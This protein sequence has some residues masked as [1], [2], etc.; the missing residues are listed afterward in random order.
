MIDKNR[1]VKLYWSESRSMQEIA[2]TLGVSLHKVAYWMDKHNIDRRSRSDAGYLKHNPN[3]DPFHIKKPKNI[4]EA[5]LFGMG[6]GLYWGEGTKADKNSVRLGNADPN[7]IN[8]FIGFLCEMCGVN[9]EKLRFQLQI[10]N[11]S[12]ISEE[13]EFWISKLDISK[14]QM[15]KTMV[16][17]SRGNGTYRKKLEHG[18]ITL[19]YGNTKLRNELVKLLPI[20]HNR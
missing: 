20:W 16:T 1:L 4:N 12:D 13:E 5:H 2:D 15:Y 18:V 14:S 17:P 3:G 10:F 8:V 7:L 11:D 9:K 6:L 19:Y